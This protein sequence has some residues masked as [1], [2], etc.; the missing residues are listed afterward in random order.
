MAHFTDFLAQTLVDLDN[1]GQNNNRVCQKRENE[2][3]LVEKKYN[4]KKRK[5]AAAVV[6]IQE[7]T[8]G[9]RAIWCYWIGEIKYTPHPFNSRKYK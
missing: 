7:V 8:G 9:P 3:A 4:S 2:N 6:R 5:S 1:G